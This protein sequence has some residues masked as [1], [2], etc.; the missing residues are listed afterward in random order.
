[1][2][3]TLQPAELAYDHLMSTQSG[4]IQDLNAY[5]GLQSSSYIIGSETEPDSTFRHEFAHQQPPQ[6]SGMG[7]R[8]MGIQ[9][10]DDARFPSEG[11]PQHSPV[12][13]AE[14]N[15]TSSTPSTIPFFS[16]T[17]PPAL[18]NPSS[19]SNNSPSYLPSN[20]SSYC[21]PDIKQNYN[22]FSP[23]DMPPPSRSPHL[24]QISSSMSARDLYSTNTQHLRRNS[25]ILNRS[26]PL[27]GTMRNIPMSPTS[28]GGFTSPQGL[29]SPQAVNNPNGLPPLN[30]TELLC[31][32]IQT[33][34]G[35]QIRPEIIG[36]I[37]KGFFLAENDWTCYR[38]NY[39][40]ISCSYTLHPSVPT[41]TAMNI[42]Q[43]GQTMQIHALAMSISAVVDGE[44]GKPI[45][46]VQHTPKRDKGPQMKPDRVILLPRPVNTTL[47]N[48]I[49]ADG[50]LSSGGRPLFDPNYAQV[51]NRPPTEC[52]FERIQFK[53]ATANNG[54]R[55]AR[56]QYYHLIVELFADLGPQLGDGRWT[57]IARRVS[58]QMVVRGRSPGHYQPDR[59]G[60]N[61]SA[62]PGGANDQG[63]GI[64]GYG[65]NGSIGGR[66][67]DVSLS[68]TSNLM[69]GS[70]YGNSY[71]GS[72]SRRYLSAAG[73]D[74]PPEPIMGTEDEK[75][76]HELEGY[77]FY[78]HPM[79]EGSISSSLRSQPLPPYQPH[80]GN[81]RQLSNQNYPGRVKQE[82]QHTGFN[83]PSLSNGTLDAFGRHCG[84]FDGVPSTRGYYPSTTIV[85]SEINSS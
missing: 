32:N 10:S 6:P 47:Y 67:G 46:L 76:F 69:S 80:R 12:Y 48:G 30:P 41:G 78:P 21:L 22:S 2:T 68:G 64:N 75:S 24:P 38:R 4:N 33:L 5:P 77:Y 16:N 7:L 60:S 52:T 25:E 27:V 58:A 18:T 35:Q 81:R 85:Q 9:A 40:Q 61:A 66:S 26:P 1:M 82:T 42:I 53:Q 72:K 57:K 62:G 65:S 37:D 50:S 74:V 79:H 15:L 29:D 43:G 54:K 19:Y 63:N 70:S 44:H 8:Y 51:S 20:L 49:N 31:Q 59:R 17:F 73:I 71:D 13:S 23:I 3:E 36:K 56:Q 34:E 14:P 55:R 39:F 84:R 28:S 11:T 45:E 83:L